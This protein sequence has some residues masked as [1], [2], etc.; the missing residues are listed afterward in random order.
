MRK[1]ND[2]QGEQRSPAKRTE[3]EQEVAVAVGGAAVGAAV[4]VMAGPLGA[5]VGAVIGAAVGAIA[6]R[7][8]E[9]DHARRA[10]VDASLDAE[11]GK[12]EAVVSMQAVTGGDIGMPKL[13]QSTQRERSC[14][15]ASSGAGIGESQT[16]A[17]NLFPDEDD[18]PAP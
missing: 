4:G 6:E 15:A 9:R 14:S 12:R 17:G 8:L 7:A 11:I 5:A 10:S 2:G 18:W 3:F 1:T 16:A 13:R